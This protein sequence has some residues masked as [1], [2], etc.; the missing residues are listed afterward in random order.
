MSLASRTHFEVLG[1]GLEPCI[2]DSTSCSY[3]IQ[4]FC[5]CCL[6][7]FHMLVHCCLH[8]YMLV[9]L[10]YCVPQ[11]KII[12]QGNSF[13]DV[14]FRFPSAQFLGL[15]QMVSAVLILYVGKSIGVVSFPSFNNQ[16]PK[17]VIF[18]ISVSYNCIVYNL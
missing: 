13:Y 9:H 15:G 1:L 18:F 12:K 17:Q 6:W 4:S 7:Q 3:C 8:L 16:I 10:G 11:F 5:C 2:L 14:I